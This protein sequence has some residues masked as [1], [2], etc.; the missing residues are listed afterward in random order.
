M[1]YA[2]LDEE[3]YSAVEGVVYPAVE[4]SSVLLSP[5]HWL[6]LDSTPLTNPLIRPMIPPRPDEVVAAVAEVYDTLVVEGS[7]ASVTEG[8]YASVVEG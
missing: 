6:M 7:Y 2:L 1:T 8:S 4:L 5:L 3:M